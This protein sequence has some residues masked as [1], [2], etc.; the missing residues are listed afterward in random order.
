MPQPPFCA[1]LPRVDDPELAP[2]VRQS[3]HPYQVSEFVITAPGN[4]GGANYG[5]PSFS[6]RTGLLYATGKND[7]W[8]IKVKPVGDTLEPGPGFVGHFGNIE[9]TGD[10]GVTATST[11]AAYNPASGGQVWYA[12]GLGSTSGG[13]LVT[14]GNVVF[15]GDG[16][17]AFYGFDAQTGERLFTYS[18]E[19]GIHASPLSYQVNGTQYVAIAAT[20]KILVFGLP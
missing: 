6:P 20:N 8:S 3:F 13:N 16:A 11:L 4:T 17:G 1:T 7:A 19:S 9:E 18:D 10:T 14:A 2:R 15:Q 5:S 12:D